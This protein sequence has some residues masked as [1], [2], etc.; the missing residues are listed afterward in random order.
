M[1]VS[2]F[3]WSRVR[4]TGLPADGFSTVRFP[5]MSVNPAVARGG[6]TATKSPKAKTATPTLHP[7]LVHLPHD[8]V[9]KNIGVSPV[10]GDADSKFL[11]SL[12][13]ARW[14]ASLV[15]TARIL[16][17]CNRSRMISV[18]SP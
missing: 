13:R 2:L 5:D 8:P 6:A 3:V 9:M 18:I 10:F 11:F 17:G 4:L 15:P 14:K 7:S 12:R 1:L 16:V